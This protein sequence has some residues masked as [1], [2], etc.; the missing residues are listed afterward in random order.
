MRT[1]VIIQARM[2]S[3][4]FPGKVLYEVAGKPLLEYLLERLEHCRHCDMVVVATS[5]EESDD[6]IE[7]FCDGRGVNCYRGSLDNVA[8][9]FNGAAAEY[10]F[11][12][13]VRI[14][15]DSPL[16]D[17][18]LVDRLIKIFAEGEFDLVTNILERTFPKGQSVEVLSR[19]TF[20]RT[21]KLMNEPLDHEHVTR[22]FYDRQ[23]EFRIFNLLNDIDY[24]WLQLTIDNPD[25]IAIF[26]SMLGVMDRP[27]WEYD[28]EEILKLWHQAAGELKV[29]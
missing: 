19:G 22:Y 23:D 9:R 2:S 27:H 29:G 16:L 7:R 13:F 26:S 20:E 8:E 17:Y 18:R 6:D 15:A 24:S 5:M 21:I 10:G 4:R 3:E 12:S 1:G 25:D 11:D 28:L 14:C